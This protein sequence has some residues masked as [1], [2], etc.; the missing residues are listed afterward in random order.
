MNDDHERNERKKKR[1]SEMPKVRQEYEERL[2][3]EYMHEWE[4]L[5]ENFR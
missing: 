3:K 2:R 5:R 4:R 1:E